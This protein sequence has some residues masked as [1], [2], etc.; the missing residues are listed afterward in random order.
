MDY[1]KVQVPYIGNLLIK[2]KAKKF[3]EKYWDK[4]LPVI[5]E[6]IIDVALEI[7]IIPIPCF[8]WPKQKL[9]LM[10]NRNKR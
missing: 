4:I 3:R 9:R 2:N 1:S 6:K 5:I 8:L 7:N 10:G